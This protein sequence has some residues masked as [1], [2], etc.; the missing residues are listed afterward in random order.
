MT[1]FCNSLLKLHKNQKLSDDESSILREW[2][3]SK[4]IDFKD[5]VERTNKN[6]VSQEQADEVARK[7]SS[8]YQNNEESECRCDQ[9]VWHGRMLFDLNFN[10]K[11]LREAFFAGILI[12][13]TSFKKA[14]LRNSSFYCSLLD[15]VDFSEADLRGATFEGATFGNVKFTRCKIGLFQRLNIYYRMIVSMVE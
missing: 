8:W 7:H 10:D 5:F 12:E 15:N 14:D 3:K 6:Y 11:D 2:C 9:A 13:N 4:G 1:E